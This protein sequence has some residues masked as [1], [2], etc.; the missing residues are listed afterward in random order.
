MA[1]ELIKEGWTEYRRRTLAPIGAGAVQTEETRKAF[2]FGAIWLFQS[3]IERMSP[4]HE[5]T[6]ADLA[7]MDDL[8]AE[9]DAFV[10]QLKRTPRR[11]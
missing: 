2:Y 9:S 6:A 11:G 10:A 1:A 4:E 8:Q 7:M 3:I 5:P